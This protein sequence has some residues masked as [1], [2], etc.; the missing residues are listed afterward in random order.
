M[1]ELTAADWF[2][3]EGRGWVASILPPHGVHDPSDLMGQQVLIDGTEYKVRGV[4]KHQ[5]ALDNRDYSLPFGLL[6]DK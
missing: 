2:H 5:I 4:E 6:T 1:V 3:I